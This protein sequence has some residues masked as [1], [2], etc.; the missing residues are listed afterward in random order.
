MSQNQN[1][2]TYLFLLLF[3]QNRPMADDINLI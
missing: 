1:N 2:I 3:V